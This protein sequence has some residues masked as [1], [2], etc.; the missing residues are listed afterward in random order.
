MRCS[1]DAA[2]VALVLALATAAGPATRAV[3]DGGSKLS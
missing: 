3:D 1:R 2:I